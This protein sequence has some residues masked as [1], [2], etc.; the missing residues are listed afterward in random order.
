MAS[1]A[2]AYRTGATDAQVRNGAGVTFQFVVATGSWLATALPAG[3]LIAVPGGY[4]VDFRILA[5]C[6][7]WVARLP[8]D[9]TTDAIVFSEHVMRCTWLTGLFDAVSSELLP[10]T[11]DTTA[12][13]LSHFIMRGF[14]SKAPAVLAARELTA[15]SFVTLRAWSDVAAAVAPQQRP[16][17]MAW[18]MAARLGDLA[19]TTDRTIPAAA[20]MEMIIT[21][22]LVPSVYSEV[23][24]ELYRMTA[25]DRSDMPDIHTAQANLIARWIWH[26]MPAFKMR[27]EREMKEGMDEMS[28]LKSDEEDTANRAD[29]ADPPPGSV[30]DSVGKGFDDDMD[31]LWDIVA[32]GVTLQHVKPGVAIAHFDPSL[33]H[34]GSPLRYAGK[35][36]LLALRARALPGEWRPYWGCALR[37][38]ASATYLLAVLA[39]YVFPDL[40]REDK[41]AAA[42]F[43]PSDAGGDEL[44]RAARARERT[45]K[46]RKAPLAG[47]LAR[48]QLR[49]HPDGGPPHAPRWRPTLAPMVAAPAPPNG[50]AGPSGLSTA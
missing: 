25:T 48:L 37:E 23:A 28:Q 47:E 31:I 46:R 16:P 40:L 33:I 20:V 32:G 2:F 34:P 6:A 8:A 39:R 14:E 26:N 17:E 38:E 19:V 45:F 13:A 12:A 15:A 3:A 21:D 49:R 29:R 42:A 27:C 11:F 50:A 1:H 4:G 5:Y 10:Q 7:W 9:G 22:R 35:R 41:Q 24:C 18:Y 43:F 30:S 44:A 36:V